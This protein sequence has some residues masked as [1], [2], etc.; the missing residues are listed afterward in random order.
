MKAETY[1]TVPEIVEAI[2]FE[3]TTE[4][5][6]AIKKLVGDPE[7][8]ATKEHQP[9]AIAEIVFKARTVLGGFTECIARQGDWIVKSDSGLIT[10]LED[11]LFG[12]IYVKHIDNN[13]TCNVADLK[14]V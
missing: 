3:Y 13:N 11:S 14:S 12:Y 2:Q 5:I 6:E 8:K 10:I 9:H 7:T 4:C 1:Q